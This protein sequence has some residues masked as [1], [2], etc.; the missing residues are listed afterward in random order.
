MVFPEIEIAQSLADRLTW[1]NI[2]DYLPIDPEYSFVEIAVPESFRGKSLEQLN[3]RREFG[4][5][6]VGV[7]D[8]LT[9][10]LKMFPAGDFQIGPDDLLLMVGKETDIQ[11]LKKRL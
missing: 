1:P 11:K 8:V 10:K 3:L 5:W 9:G 6:V 7:K 2:V 4:V